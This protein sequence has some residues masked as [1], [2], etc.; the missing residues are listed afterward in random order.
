MNW[1]EQGR[2]RSARLGRKRNL[3]G[4]ESAAGKPK[5]FRPAMGKTLTPPLQVAFPQL[6]D[7]LETITEQ[8]PGIRRSDRKLG[9]E[10]YSE[11]GCWLAHIGS[12]IHLC[13]GDAFDE[14]HDAGAGRAP[15]FDWQ[16]WLS[17]GRG[18]DSLST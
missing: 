2:R 18:P 7:A 8:N 14:Q 12:K 6:F 17:N 10:T 16:R 3:L 11:V 4:N 5:A 9:E 13:G 1:L 15:V